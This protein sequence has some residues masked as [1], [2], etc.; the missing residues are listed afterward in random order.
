MFLEIENE[1]YTLDLEKIVNFVTIPNKDNKNIESNQSLVYSFDEK[2]E[3]K[4]KLISKQL[5]E[6]KSSNTENIN[7]I[8]YDLTKQLLDVILNIGVT[9]N[10][11]GEVIETEISDNNSLDSFSVGEVVAFNTFLNEGFLINIKQDNHG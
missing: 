7:A 5:T 4:M 11:F 6:N 2:D 9:T 3:S 8:K 10:P 1:I